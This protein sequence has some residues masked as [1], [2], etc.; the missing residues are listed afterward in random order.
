M[1]VDKNKQALMETDGRQWKQL[2]RCVSDVF[3][4]VQMCL[5]VFGW[6]GGWAL[7]GH[8]WAWME[9]GVNGMKRGMDG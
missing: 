4:C 1:G 2:C 3:G 5:D 8:R 6:A 9:M 7:M